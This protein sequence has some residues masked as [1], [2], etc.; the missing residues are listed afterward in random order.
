MDT[1]LLLLQSCILGCGV[2]SPSGTFTATDTGTIQVSATHVPS[3]MVEYTTIVVRPAQ[4][5]INECATPNPAWIW[6]DDFEVDR[7]NRYGEVNYTGGYG[8][9]TNA[10][11][12]GSIGMKGTFEPDSKYDVAGWMEVNFG[13]IPKGPPSLNYAKPVDGGTANYRQIYWRFFLR[14]DVD[15]EGGNGEKLTRATVYANTSRAQAMIAHAWAH[16]LRPHIFLLDP[17]RG[18]D[19]AGNLKTTKWNDFPNLTKGMPTHAKSSLMPTG[20]EW[21]CV[22][23]MVKLNDP[24]KSNGEMWYWKN[25]SLE[26]SLTTYNYLGAYNEYGINAVRLENGWSNAKTGVWGPPINPPKVQSRYFDNFV[27]STERIGCTTR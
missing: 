9:Y 23:F 17:A 14:T 5:T 19:E 13:R 21:V 11:Y 6:C 2:I 1:L 10:G 25:D 3:S 18:T 15:W 12:G 27:V 4:V 16:N 24:G 22:E 8:R 20:G 7:L 26:A